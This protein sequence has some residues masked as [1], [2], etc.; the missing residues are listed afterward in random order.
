M[1]AIGYV[2][3]EG[4][5]K[6]VRTVQGNEDAGHPGMALL[7]REAAFLSFPQPVLFG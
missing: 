2:G 5:P 3:P 6:I 1:L 7:D 4:T